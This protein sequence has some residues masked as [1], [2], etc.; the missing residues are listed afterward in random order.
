VTCGEAEALLVD[1]GDGRLDLPATTRLSVHIEGCA[2]CRARAGLW[3]QLVPGLRALAPETPDAM[4]VRRMQ[5]EI[6]RELEPAP[7]RATARLGGWRRARWPAAL[8]LAGAAALLLFWGR[9]PVGPVAPPAAPPAFATVLQI[10]GALTSGAGALAANAGLSAGTRLTLARGGHAELALERGARVRVAGPARLLLGG[11]P[12]AVAL[13]LEE[14][15]LD[16]EV[17]HR[18]AGETFAVLTPDLRVE[19]RG[20]RFTVGIGGAGGPGGSGEPGTASWVRVDEGRVEVRLS[21]GRLRAV[22]AGET[23]SSSTLAAP[24]SEATSAPGSV[25]GSS[26]QDP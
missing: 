7:R 10:Q 16:A 26:E 12:R 11:T 1:A 25:L 19:V 23:L 15:T 3:R 9:R 14:G 2:G 4:R 21:D 24:S 5:I 13:R 18:A 8:A 17:A 6:E 20:T 22:A